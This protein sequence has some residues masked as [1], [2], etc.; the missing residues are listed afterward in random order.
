M[1]QTTE[2]E[3][4]K[5]GVRLE[6]ETVWMTQKAKRIQAE[7]RQV[8]Y[9]KDLV[10]RLDAFSEFNEQDILDNPGKV[11][12]EVAEKLAIEQYEKYDQQQLEQQEKDDFDKFLEENDLK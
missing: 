6:D 7:R 2:D 1:Y 9:M 12:R 11:S 10:E 8:M 5:I 4:T 3:E